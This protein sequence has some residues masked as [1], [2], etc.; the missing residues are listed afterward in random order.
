MCQP[1]SC[2]VTS[3]ASSQHIA[4]CHVAKSRDSWGIP[5]LNHPAVAFELCGTITEYARRPSSELRSRHMIVGSAYVD[6]GGSC[7]IADLASGQLIYHGKLP[8][9]AWRERR[10]SADGMTKG[11]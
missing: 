4:S 11:G 2:K 1:C 10:Q 9:F 6:L 3:L 5:W 7:A 8:Q